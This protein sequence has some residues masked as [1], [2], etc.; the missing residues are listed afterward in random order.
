MKKYLSI[1]F[2]SA[3]L[4][5]SLISCET[6]FDNPNSASES[7]V[8]STREGVLAVAVGLKQIYSTSGL[9][10]VIET[11]AITTRE[12]ATTTTFIN[13]IELEDGGSALPNFNSN[14]IGLWSN[15]LRVV[16]ISE[17]ILSSIES[18]AL[19]PGT[20]SG[21][22]AYANLY[23]ALAIGNLSQ[24]FEQVIIATNDNNSSDFVSRQEGFQEATRLL[25]EAI[26]EIE[27]QP[28]S[29]EFTT[30]IINNE[31][32]LQNTLYAMLAR[33]SL[34]A[35]NYNEAIAAADRVDLTKISL[36]NYD[37]LN[38]NPIYARVI[39]GGAPNFKPRDNFG[40]PAELVEPGD[41]RL[42][43]YTEPL[44]AVNPNGLPIEDLAG[45]F[46]NSN[47]SIPLYIPDE[48]KLIKAEAYL[49]MA[50]PNPT[51]ALA[52]INEVRTDTSD[53]LGVNAGLPAYSGSEAIADLLLEVY[54]N[55]RAELFLTG[56]SL[57]DSRRFGRPQPSLE[58]R[59][60]T[61]ERNRNFYPY[62]DIERNNNPNTPA[63]PAI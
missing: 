38:I 32:D 26:L 35:G 2:L 60:Y 27:Q 53:P 23:K 54:K 50:T 63:D 56:M 51:A 13:M 36:F 8:L 61:D 42:E 62:P 19:E 47:E 59:V 9:R 24:N 29:G 25:N 14:V 10:F 52:L 6:D 16:K 49:R 28:V 1:K 45:F 41:G 22:S 21:L 4:I 3:F 34:F 15:M 37:A 30:E 39:L 12:A 43:F 18:I 5:V 55:R 33:Y 48:M 40:L 17:T 11:P 31:I 44:D 57:E 20:R 58:S 7:V 46:D